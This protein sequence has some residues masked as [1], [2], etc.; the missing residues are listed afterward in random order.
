M[1]SFT[2]AL[3]CGEAPSNVRV[4]LDVVS[5]FSFCRAD[6]LENA[7]LRHLFTN[8]PFGQMI[9]KGPRE[10]F[11][12][13]PCMM[14]CAKLVVFIPI[15]QTIGF[16]HILPTNFVYIEN[17]IWWLWQVCIWIWWRKKNK[18]TVRGRFCVIFIYDSLRKATLCDIGRTLHRVW[19]GHI[20][21][22]LRL[23]FVI[24]GV[25]T[26]RGWAACLLHFHKRRCIECAL[27]SM[28]S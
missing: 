23:Y 2:G 7:V 22:C 10:E 4:I 6:W 28:S 5:D 21:G 16:N 27:M 25:P 26:R 15:H 3:W 20:F 1:D 12:A 19:F 8:R 13:S 17:P 9:Q 11:L 18:K 14:E 24:S